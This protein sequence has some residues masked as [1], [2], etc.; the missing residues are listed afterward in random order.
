MTI[1]S[2]MAL[3]AAVRR[4]RPGNPGTPPG[5]SSPWGK[6]IVA[7]RAAMRPSGKARR[8]RTGAPAARGLR[9]GVAIPGVFEGGATPP[10]PGSPRAPGARPQP[11]DRLPG[12]AAE[13]DKI[14]GALFGDAAARL[15]RPHP[16]G[17]CRWPARGAVS[18]RPQAHLRREDAVRRARRD[19][20]QL[21]PEP[22]A[23]FTRG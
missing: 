11:R 5:P 21:D 15:P 16:R 17:D 12:G 22:A 20:D 2:V 4:P 3:N 19:G 1:H 9:G 10:D 7:P 8:P 23:L 18:R 13:L 6:S 14:H